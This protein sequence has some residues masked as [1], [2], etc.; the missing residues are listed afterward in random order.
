MIEL[1]VAIVVIKLFLIA[2]WVLH[3]LSQLDLRKN[4]LG[5][6]IEVGA[7]HSV[8]ADANP[9]VVAFVV[10]HINPI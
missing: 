1:V 10:T 2:S 3:T 4:K 9:K 7:S 8:E 6:G 5:L